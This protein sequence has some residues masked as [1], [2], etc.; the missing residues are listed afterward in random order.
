MAK[1]VILALKIVSDA[2]AGVKGLDDTAAAADKMQARVSK[3]S[4][5]ATA[6]L[7]TVG[8]GLLKLG[9]GAADDAE[10]QAL[11]AKSMENAAG[12]SKKQ[13]A[14]TEDWI[15][16][17][18]RATG[19]ADDQLRPALG[20]IVRA[21]GDVTKSQD[22][23]KVAMDVAAATG[24]PVE[25]VSAAI[26]KAYGG[27]TTALGRLVPGMDKTILASGDMNA[28]MAELART[29]EGSAATAADSAAGKWR[30]ARL[31]MDELGESLGAYVVPL[32]ATASEKVTSLTAFIDR[33]RTTVA[34]VVGVLAGL[35]A[36]VITVNAAVSAYRATTAAVTAV[37]RGFAAAQLV[38]NAIMSMNPIILVVLAV[39]A[40][41]AALVVA[42]KESETFRNIVQAAGRMGQQAL[43][44]VIDKAAALGRWFRNDVVPAANTVKDAGVKAFD[45]L[46]S[47]ISNVIGWIK[48]LIDWIKSIKFPSPPGWM[49]KAGGFIG[50]GGLPSAPGGGGG[51]YAPSSYGG[52]GGPGG[53]GMYML[54]AGGGRTAPVMIV[55]QGAIDPI[56]T[57][58]QLKSLM[59][60]NDVI[61]GHS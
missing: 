7:V 56:G 60:R 26:A 41:T 28:I 25:A 40:L 12:A 16:K 18:A 27:Q 37:A 36:T 35:A 52:R 33:N 19:V 45:A 57:V 53:D 39:V 1:S 54:P 49:K 29:T 55:V 61:L 14:A 22:A 5:V 50:L 46:V 24:K 9:Q 4:K 13:I 44:W 58:N 8:A 38:L 21:T 11:L 20:T 3:A 6:A 48:S 42:Y 15:D 34:A 30:R 51:G 17:M 2:K 31:S 43:Q 47:P 32:I 23:L 59:K 10:G